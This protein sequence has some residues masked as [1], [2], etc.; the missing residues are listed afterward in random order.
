MTASTWSF[1]CA[2][3]TSWIVRPNSS[4]HAGSPQNFFRKRRRGCGS[5]SGVSFGPYCSGL[6]AAPALLSPGGSVMD[7]FLPACTAPGR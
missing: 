7:A 4:I 6:A 1:G 3:E 2:L 5:G